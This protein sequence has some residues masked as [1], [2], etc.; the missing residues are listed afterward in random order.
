MMG[1]VNQPTSSLEARTI[2]AAAAD[3]VCAAILDRMPHLGLSEW[4]L[5][6][7]AVFQNVW[8]AVEGHAPGYGIKDYDVFYFD[9]TDLSWEAEDAVIRRASDLF[10]D[11]PAQIELRNEARVHLWYEAKFGTPATPFTSATDAID[12]FASTTCC[13]GLTRAS[14]DGPT[15]TQIYAPFGLDDVFA[16]H[17][18]PNR[19]LAPQTVYDAKVTD[20]RRRWPSLTSDPW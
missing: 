11:V 1:G 6:A 5:T 9:D 14:A 2:A 13:V 18:R 12:S 8:N 7:G 20:Y 19:R 3:P 15:G 10:H 17:M 4:W 16:M